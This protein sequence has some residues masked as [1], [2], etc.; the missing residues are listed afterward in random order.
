MKQ[1]DNVLIS[2]EVWHCRFACDL[3]QCLGKC[4]QYGDVGSPVGEKEVAAIEALLPKLEPVL[5][6]QH[7]KFLKAG[8]TERFRGRL[9]IRE[10]NKDHPCPLS[11]KD[12]SGIIYCSLHDYTLKNNRPLLSA[13]PL[14]CSLFPLMITK[15]K[16]GWFINS[17]ILDFCRTKKDA[18]PMLL[19]FK[20]VL[21]HIFGD[22]WFAK[23][24]AEYK[25]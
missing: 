20:E 21:C 3:T 13:K 4:C 16:T 18:P 17:S 22:E 9:H 23:V 2:D 6:D 8:V 15:T 12:K 7:V 14:W 24:E 11:F 5:C 10:I 25:R 19:S 1:I